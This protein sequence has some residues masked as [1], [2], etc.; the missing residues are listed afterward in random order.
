MNKFERLICNNSNVVLAR[1]AANI[2]TNAKIAQ[3][4]IINDLT[5]KLMDVELRIADATDFAPD[6]TVSLTPGSKNWDAKVWAQNLQKLKMEKYNI[7]I[8]LKLAQET[9]DEFFKDES[10]VS[11]TEDK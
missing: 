2:T 7:E 10:I 4:T 9:Y 1:R 8:N 11:E 3:Q 5:Q 6:S